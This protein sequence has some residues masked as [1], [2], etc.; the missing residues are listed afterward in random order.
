M[1]RENEK[2]ECRLL[3]GS[4]K[5]V[6]FKK[7]LTYREQQNL[8]N[9][10]IKA[11]MIDGKINMDVNYPDMWSDLYVLLFNDTNVKIDDIAMDDKICGYIGRQLD[12]LLDRITPKTKEKSEDSSIQDGVSQKE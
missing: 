10:H 2:V 12:F 1:N 4:T 8:L 6:D 11:K 5:V 7:F 3:D 9:K